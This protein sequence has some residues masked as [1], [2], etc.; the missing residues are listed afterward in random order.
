MVGDELVD[1][2][3]MDVVTWNS[4]KRGS[5]EACAETSKRFAYEELKDD[6]R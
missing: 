1:G 5:I 6:N 4:I 2:G 3:S